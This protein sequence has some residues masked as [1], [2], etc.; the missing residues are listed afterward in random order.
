MRIMLKRL[1]KH[2]RGATAIEYA[3]LASLIAMAVIGAVML[4]GQALEGSYND[5][6]DQINAAVG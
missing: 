5:T 1:L 2:S 6:S 3:L 4:T